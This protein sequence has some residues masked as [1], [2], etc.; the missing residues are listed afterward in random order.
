VGELQLVMGFYERTETLKLQVYAGGSV[1]S[2]YLVL[3]LKSAGGRA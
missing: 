3:G 1:A 2:I